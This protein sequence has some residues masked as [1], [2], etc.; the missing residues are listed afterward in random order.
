MPKIKMDILEAASYK[1]RL[2][3]M[4]ADLIQ[5][6]KLYSV[7]LVINAFTGCSVLAYSLYYFINQIDKFAADIYYQFMTMDVIFAVVIRY[8]W[9]NN[10]QIL[11]NESYCTYDYP[12]KIMEKKREEV[13]EKKAKTFKRNFNLIF[14]LTCYTFI[15]LTLYGLIEGIL[16]GEDVYLLFPCWLPFN[17]DNTF[18][19]I[20]VILWQAILTAN[21][22][23]MAFGGLGILYIP[24][25]HIKAEIAILKFALQ[26][27][28][29][30][31]KEMA[32]ERGDFR[33]DKDKKVDQ[34]LLY[35]SHLS[36][37][38]SCAEHHVE[39]M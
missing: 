39:I 26:K 3:L 28:Q 36:C 2:L 38:R 30:R 20:V 9:P 10:L 24:Y 31:S 25:E 33:K 27:M 19:Y 14:Y 7:F 22:Q 37:M 29:E 35:S 32:E 18:L 13:V 1:M 12:G 34:L 17:L 8:Y 6:H 5:I 23:F 16:R 21:M 15:N 11:I 4:G